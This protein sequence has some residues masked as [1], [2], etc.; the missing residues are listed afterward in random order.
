MGASANV[1][2]AGLV[3]PLANVGV[4]LEDVQV[5]RA[6]RREVVRVV[7]DKDGGVDLDTVADVSRIVSALLD[8]PP[9]SD[10]FAGAYVLEVTSPG[11]D[12]PLTEPRHWR[13]ATGRLVDIAL[14]DGTTLRARVRDVEGDT[15]TVDLDPGGA[16]VLSVPEILRGSVQIEFNRTD[17]EA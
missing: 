14:V 12:R 5:Q 4:D 9:L 11:V 6:G 13:R 7:V 15:V 17:E 8:A 3:E 2:T 1:L 10:Q 16:R